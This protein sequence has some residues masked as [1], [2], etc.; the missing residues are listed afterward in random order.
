MFTPISKTTSVSFFTLPFTTLKKQLISEM[1]QSEKLTLVSQLVS[2]DI[3]AMHVIKE[4]ISM[5]GSSTLHELF[6]DAKVQ[7]ELLVGLMSGQLTDSEIIGLISRVPV[8]LSF[9][10]SLDIWNANFA[11]L[12]KVLPTQANVV[13]ALY[14]LHGDIPLEHQLPLAK[15]SFNIPF[16]YDVA[17]KSLLDKK[18]K[19]TDI[20]AQS[21]ITW[22]LKK[23]SA[24]IGEE[25]AA[26]TRAL[27]SNNPHAAAVIFYHL[28]EKEGVDRSLYD[29]LREES[30]QQ[31]LL[32]GL[33]KGTVIV[34]IIPYLY[35]VPVS[36]SEEMRLSIWNQN[37]EKFLTVLPTQHSAINALYLLGS[38]QIPESHQYPLA[39]A[40]FGMPFQHETLDDIVESGLAF[41]LPKFTNDDAKALLACGLMECA[42]MTYS[43]QLMH[44]FLPVWDAID[45]DIERRQSSDF[46]NKEIKNPVSN[47]KA[48]A[49]SRLNGFRLLL[50][51]FFVQP[52]LFDLTL[53]HRKI[54]KRILE[55]SGKLLSDESCKSKHRAELEKVKRLSQGRMQELDAERK[56]SYDELNGL[57]EQLN[58]L[59]E[60]QKSLVSPLPK[61]K[62]EPL[63]LERMDSEIRK[64]LFDDAGEASSLKEQ[65]SSSNNT[66]V[67]IGVAALVAAVGVVGYQ[68]WNRFQNPDDPN[69]L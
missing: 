36:L 2:G 10:D 52:E 67:L 39:K 34:E 29:F 54:L 50:I 40:L 9:Q 63:D 16:G 22:K 44:F 1:N 62:A 27:C 32:A 49:C 18:E 35:R 6:S 46:P 65:T 21:L 8:A 31:A 5:A 26:F 57:H 55:S 41:N 20:A 42:S 12:L 7:K 68:L 14:L 51:A 56:K 61:G 60:E 24:M 33:M 11:K 25:K 23:V 13:G 37:F 28:S 4:N 3:N 48:L 64:K 45:V 15:A 43:R 66:G 17:T 69:N 59:S 58:H 38:T 30:V 53:S 47:K 19:F